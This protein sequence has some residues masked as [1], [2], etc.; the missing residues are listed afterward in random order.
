MDPHGL[1]DQRLDDSRRDDQISWSAM[2]PLK[3]LVQH[4]S[5]YLGGRVAL[6]LLGFA[7]FPVF[8][9]VFSVAD[10]GTLNLIQ[11]TVLLL[12]VV[13]KF[14]FQQA[15]QRYYPEYAGSSDPLAVRRYYSTLF[16]GT[17]L[18]ASVLTSVFVGSV[19]LGL[20]RFLGMAATG[21]LLLACSLIVIRA[22]RSMQLNLMQM[23]NKTRLF[24]AME[25]IQKA[26]AIGLTVLL[27][28][29]W[30]KSILACF[31]AMVAVES[32]VMLQYL[33]ALARRRLLS[34][35]LF[36]LSFFRSAAVFSFP[37]MIAEI[38]WVLLASADRFF[39]QH[40]L[41]VVAVGY[42]AAAYGIAVYV[43]EVI[44]APLQLS[45]FPICM[46]LWSAE[47]KEQ[48]QRFL[49]RSLNYFMMI[50]VL[51]VGVA[52]VTS[53][54]VV[55]LLAS[56]KFQ[57]A[58]ILLPYLVI[59]L[60]LCAAN[61]F[62]R[63]GLM[64]HKRAHKIAQ[65]TLSASLLNIV[66]NIV[67]LPRMG[68]AGAALAS[69]LSFVA[70]VA[71][72]AYESLRVLPFTIDWVAFVRYAVVGVGT[73]WAASLISVASPLGAAVLKGMAILI[74][75]M[76]T[77]WIIDSRMREVV[78]HLIASITQATR[79]RRQARVEPLAVATEN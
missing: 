72:T 13:A 29:T 19:A 6:M 22:L 8:T 45:F 48:T 24:N 36:D 52:I 1:K 57:Q 66:L 63:P 31:V 55:I 62:F 2:T 77:L 69:V 73:S 61:T 44:M 18:L 54:N 20:G 53:G 51:V 38:S 60:V 11:N 74:L 58:R 35:A 15:V 41:G 46:K 32:A 25:I 79:N 21:T 34:P 70:M 47:G 68:L 23:E 9:R 50:A 65:T 71:F 42:Y 30:R 4:S 12:T 43:Q 67:L 10:Y 17:G 5:H 26:A 59:G 27:L 75:Y 78:V 56:K 39:V 64:I 76:G 33:P 40:Y 16:F 14:G 7:S 28:F 49:S 3:T 37:L